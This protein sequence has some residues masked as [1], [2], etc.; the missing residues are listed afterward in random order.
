[1]TL[2]VLEAL[3]FAPFPAGVMVRPLR[4]NEQAHWL[5]LIRA[6]EPL[7]EIPN[8]QFERAYGT[9]PAQIAE[10][11]YFAVGPDGTPIGTIAAWFGVN[12]WRGWGRIHWLYVRPE[13]QGK[14][15]GRALL[16][17]ALNRLREL[18]HT[19]VYLRT[20]TGRP[21]AIRLYESYGFTIDS[22]T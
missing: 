17:F 21:G 13:W 8:D 20:S 14:G 2:P 1:M 6:A 3:P 5:S 11:I 22:S 4:N 15:L 9:D 16:V 18:G 10:R 12:E 19:K 7:A